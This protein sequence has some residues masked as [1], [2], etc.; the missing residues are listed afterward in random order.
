MKKQYTKKQI[1]EAIAYWEKQL[2]GGDYAKTDESLE[3]QPEA[4]ERQFAFTEN[5]TNE[6]IIGW[7]CELYGCKNGSELYDELVSDEVETWEGNQTA[8]DDFDEFRASYQDMISED[9]FL[10]NLAEAL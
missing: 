4:E 8:V 1:S 9:C 10:D 2:A 6:D 3:T 7:V 5:T